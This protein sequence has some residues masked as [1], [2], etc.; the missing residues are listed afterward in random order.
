[1]EIS[2]ERNNK[3]LRKEFQRSL[4]PVMTA[5]LGGTIN[6]IIDSAFVTRRLDAK[7]LSAVTYSMPVFLVLCM[8]GCLFGVGSSILSSKA[9]GKNDVEEA[10]KY[11][12]SL[13]FISIVTGLLFTVMGLAL[14]HPIARLLC[15]DLELISRVEI[16]TRITLIGAPFYILIYVPNYYLQL[17]GKG[18]SLTT[19]MVVMIITD[20]LLDFVLLYIF[21]MGLAGASLASVLSVAAACVIGMY[22]LLFKDGMFGFHR[23]RFRLYGLKKIVSYGSV[24]A[25][26]TLVGVL[27]LILLNRIIFRAA[28]NDGMAV[29]SVL[30]ALSELS[31]CILAGIPRTALP[32]LGI[33]SS[34]HDNE[35]LRLIAGHELKM[36]MRLCTVY[37]IVLAAL[38]VPLRLFYKIDGSMLLP[39]VCLGI[40]VI[41]ALCASVLASFYNVTGRPIV[42]N[43]LM[44]LR[45]F[46]LPVLSAWIIMLTGAPI[47]LFLPLGMTLAALFAIIISYMISAASKGSDH[48]LSPVL[49]LDDYLEKNGMIKGFSI[50]STDEEICRA[51][52]VITEFCTGHEMEPGKAMK[53][54]LS[55]EELMTVMVRKSKPRDDD[56]VDIRVYSSDGV[57]GLSIMC[58]GDKYDPF[59]SGDEKDEMNMGVNMIKKMSRD[60]KYL[61]TMGMNILS[62]EF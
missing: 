33:A 53:L 48:E 35:G 56:P 16:Y 18:R 38:N 60:H 9:I 20:I 39:I 45:T 25:N 40:S 46:A 5:V 57:F 49:L 6:A 42:A 51:S 11:F 24:S 28:G 50:R 36:G 47:F 12:H 19:M 13:L 61:Y 55:L 8:M 2:V 7:A 17:D 3:F 23:K 41:P 32:L 30:N 21:D 43:I 14:S 62:V 52:E 58:F 59:E 27:R 31:L 10:S 37:A 22:P 15:S 4:I 54:G 26:G 1:M 44:T 29:W 34:G